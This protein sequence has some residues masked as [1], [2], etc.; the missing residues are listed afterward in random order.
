MISAQAIGGDGFGQ[1]EA[2][3]RGDEAENGG[4]EEGGNQLQEI[5][6][7]LRIAEAEQKRKDALPVDEGDGQNRARPG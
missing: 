2:E 7:V 5:V 3:L 1:L 4:D 6:P